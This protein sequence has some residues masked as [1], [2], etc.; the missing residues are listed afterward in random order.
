MRKFL[1]IALLNGFESFGSCDRG[2][3]TAGL[4]SILFLILSVS[5]VLV[6]VSL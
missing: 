2:A 3:K 6:G 4:L 1:F 5:S